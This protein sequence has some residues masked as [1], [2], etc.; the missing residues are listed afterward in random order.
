M[1][2]DVVALTR[3]LIDVE[4][5][6]GNEA[7]VG[8]LLVREL[9]ALGYQVSRMPVEEERFNVWATSP[10]HQRPKVVFSTHMDVVPPWIPS[11]EDEKNIYGRGAC[12]AKGIIAAQIDAAE[13]LRTKGIH[14]GL[15]FVVG[16]ERD[17]T[18]A[19]VANSHAPGSKFLINGEPTDN[20]IGVASKGAL[21][22]N[23][24][25]EGK[26]A[27]SAY[28]ELGESAI[29]KLLNAL[30]RLRKMPLPENPEV[31]PCTVNIGVIEGGRAP[32]VIP[33]QASAQLLFRLVG[34]SEQL[35]KDIE[36]AI[37]PDAH[38]EYALEIPFVKLRTVPD[39]PT[40]TAK[41]TTD[42]PRLSN[43]GEPVLLGPG[44]IHVAHTPREFLSKQELFEAV[45][46][47]VKVAEFFNAQPGA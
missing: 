6:T 22:V 26:M 43:W 44:S 31:G 15:L 5:I 27:H 19:Y 4:S 8:E 2:F 28:P 36:T 29:E 3:K 20:R 33:D 47:Y 9:S 42:I 46:L 1:S 17:S 16:E 25:A 32:N 12:D 7:P 41:F 40:M 39:I 10:G 13:K 11:S 24:I 30:E 23:V 37:A 38:C 18:G 14:A 21:R 35:R 45:E 34:P